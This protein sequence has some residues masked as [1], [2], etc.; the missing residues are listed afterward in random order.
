MTPDLRTQVAS[1]A[2]R[3]ISGAYLDDPKYE[4]AD[5]AFYRAF[6]E[7]EEAGA[8]RDALLAL[9]EHRNHAEVAATRAVAR[10]VLDRAGYGVL[11]ALMRS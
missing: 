2:E 6:N 9:E 1:A 8:P 11:D 4:E 5:V 3:L 7:L 10:A